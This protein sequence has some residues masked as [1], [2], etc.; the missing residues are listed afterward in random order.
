MTRNRALLT[1]AI[2]VAALSWACITPPPTPT[3]TS[4]SVDTTT[5]AP[6]STTTSTTTTT[7]QPTTTTTTTTV[8]SGDW[9]TEFNT[10]P[11]V[12]NPP[13]LGTVH[14]GPGETRTITQAVTDG[15]V[16]WPGA[17]VMLDHIEAHGEI[18]VMARHGDATTR[19]RMTDSAAYNGMRVNTV[20]ASENL[21]WGHQVY[22][23]IRVDDSWIWYPQGSGTQHTEALS[24][25]GWPSG[26]VFEHTSFIQQG[27]F[28]G[29][30]TATVNWHGVN[31]LFDDCYFGWSDGI[32]A[33]YTVYV[34]GSGNV[35]RNSLFEQARGG[36]IY[37]SNPP[38]TYI[39]NVDAVTGAPVEP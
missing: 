17:N 32:A 27:P 4:T 18:Y 35:V 24:S 29:T 3:T 23:D 19:F 12:A 8:P 21:D 1:L 13:Y 9:P 39:G 25:F 33:W 16:V 14:V 37:P 7:T 30:A 34:E 26:T 28:N 10:G 2:F 15:I 31:T 22:G 6:G 11:T 38:A 36:Y 5:T 20:D